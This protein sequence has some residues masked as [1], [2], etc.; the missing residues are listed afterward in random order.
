MKQSLKDLRRGLVK[1][2][3]PVGVC[4]ENAVCNALENS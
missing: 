3:F 4:A 1:L 2:Y